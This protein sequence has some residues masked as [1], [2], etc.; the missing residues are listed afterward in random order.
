M[1]VG[2]Q[3][4]PHYGSRGAVV[5]RGPDYVSRGAGHIVVVGGAKGAKGATL[6]Y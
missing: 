6:W 5:E 2:G 3:R 1:V 4:G